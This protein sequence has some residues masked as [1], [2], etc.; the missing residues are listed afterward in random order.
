MTTQNPATLCPGCF[1]ETGGSNP[2]P[3][4]AFDERAPRPAKTLALRTLL[5]GQFL[6]GRVLGKP[7]GFG[8][9]Y[10]G[11]DLGLRRRVAIKE[12]FPR[13]IA[14][15]DTDRTTVTPDSTDDVQNFGYGL[16]QFQTEAR[17]LARLDHP[18]IVRIHQVLAAHGTAY[19]AMEYYP[20][21]TLAEYLDRQPGGRLP[22]STALALMQPILDGLRAVHA[23]GLLHRDIKPQNI[24]LAATR[25]GGAR[26]VLIDFGAARQVAGERSRSLSVLLTPGYA[27]LEQY[28]RR[29]HQGPWTDVYAIAAVLYRMLTGTTPPDAHD[30]TQGEPLP[31]AV[32]FGI[33][34][35][36]SAA[37]DR[38]LA[39]APGERHQSVV[40]FQQ[41]LAGA[42]GKDVVEKGPG[43]NPPPARPRP[44]GKNSRTAPPPTTG[45]NGS[46]PWVVVG[47]LGLAIGA[48]VYV[49]LRDAAPVVPMTAPVAAA[50]GPTASAPP[51]PQ[52]APVVPKP[53][54]PNPPARLPFEPEMVR[55]PAGSFLMGS[56]AG[57]PER[58]DNEGPQHQ[59]QVSAFELGKYEVT[60]A[61]FS[62]FTKAA[63]YR[64]DAE[65]NVGNAV[66]CWIRLEGEAAGGFRAGKHW[67]DPGMQQTE[68]DPVVCMSWNDAQAYVE[69]LH[70]QTGQPW[71]LPSEAEWE[72]AARAGTTTAFNTGDCIKTSQA[73]YHGYFDYN[74]CGAKTGVYVGK[75]QPVGSYPVNRWG[76]YDMHG[77]AWEW[78]QDCWHQNYNGAP[79]DS[80]EWFDYCLGNERRVLRGGSWSYFPTVLR[81]AYRFDLDA[82]FRDSNLGFR[83]ARTLTP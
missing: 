43:P 57:E 56:P 42:A 36:L 28:S 12:Y 35:P 4:C 78:V 40:E 7:G 26:P 23:E 68:N 69:W 21:L 83:V 79:K 65:R 75:T 81:S 10:L 66:G 39:M 67:R 49:A 38:A 22:E 46:W 77:N 53:T 31:P 8:I 16:E 76:L 15:R 1:N 61:Q 62:A 71:R 19:L 50:P 11:W 72:Y 33:G 55:I 41:A 37:L 24:Y 29:G 80:K 45:G 51:P 3:H 60:R 59:V 47:A 27:P 6:V 74:G 9:T 58:Q 13:D 18:N 2:C 30:R 64:T 82:S 14:G 5:H 54:A 20:G 48:V 70:Q 32:Q 25:G 63:G 44:G 34:A 73:N 52:P 17:I